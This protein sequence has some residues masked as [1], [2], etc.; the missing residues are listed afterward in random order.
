MKELPKGTTESTFADR[1]R[2]TRISQ[3]LTQAEMAARLGIERSSYTYY[4]TG[5]TQPNLKTLKKLKQILD[6]SID[7]LVGD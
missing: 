3:H 7:Y 1:L 2:Q 4:E 6:V 5:K